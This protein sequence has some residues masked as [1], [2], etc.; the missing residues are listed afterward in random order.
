MKTPANMYKITATLGMQF[1]FNGVPCF[2]TKAIPVD[3][4]EEE[5]FVLPHALC[6]NELAF[7]ENNGLLW[8]INPYIKKVLAWGPLELPVPEGS[9]F[10]VKEGWAIRIG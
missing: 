9:F 4:T 10:D 2:V 6:W 1:D 5:S 3:G 8:E 7:I